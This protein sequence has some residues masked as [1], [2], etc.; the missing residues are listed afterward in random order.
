MA[1]KGAVLIYF[2]AT[3]TNYEF[4]RIW[5]SRIA[6]CDEIR[7]DAVLSAQRMRRANRTV[8]ELVSEVHRPASWSGGQSF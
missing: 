1:P 4:A 3:T 2:A 7:R 8:Q 5:Y 6:D